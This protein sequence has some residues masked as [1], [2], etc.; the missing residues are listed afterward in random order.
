MEPWTVFLH[1]SS[2]GR[3]QSREV[4]ISSWMNKVWPAMLKPVRRWSSLDFRQVPSFLAGWPE[5]MSG[6]MIL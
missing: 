2:K 1:T 3:G 6:I 4:E 5:M